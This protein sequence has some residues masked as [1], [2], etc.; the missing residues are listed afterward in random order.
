M[1]QRETDRYTDFDRQNSLLTS[2]VPS[3]L[4]LTSSSAS[5]SCLYALPHAVPNWKVGVLGLFTIS[6]RIMNILAER[7]MGALFQEYRLNMIF[8][9][10]SE[11]YF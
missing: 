6:H 7:Q 4:W 1:G 3:F 8:S 10:A 2:S 9:T 5:A 11:C